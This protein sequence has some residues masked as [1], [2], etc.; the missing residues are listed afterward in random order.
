MSSEDAGVVM[1]RLP[2]GQG[3]PF[4]FRAQVEVPATAG[5]VAVLDARVDEALAR[6]CEYNDWA[7]PG[8]VERTTEVDEAGDRRRVGRFTVTG[9]REHTDG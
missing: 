1:L 5:K 6:W 2:D 7:L 9:Y 3:Q 4:P 8:K